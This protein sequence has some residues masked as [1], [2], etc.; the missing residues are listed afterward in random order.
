M[1]Y[2]NYHNYYDKEFNDKLERRVKEIF[3]DNFAEYEFEE[4]FFYFYSFLSKLNIETLMKK[5]ETKIFN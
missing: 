3:D 5:K 2:Q 4:E 1:K